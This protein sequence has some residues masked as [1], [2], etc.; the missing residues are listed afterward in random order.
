M[1]TLNL[2]V[3]VEAA[4]ERL[5]K[6]LATAVPNVSRSRLQKLVKEGYLLDADEEVVADN[7]KKIAAGDTFTLTIVPRASD[8]PP[9]PQD[10]PLDIL[11]EDDDIIVLNKAAGMVVHRGAGVEDG[12]LVNA[13]L[14]HTGGKLSSIGMEAGRPGIVHRL[15]KDT[16]G[17][18]LACKTDA[19]HIAM[20][21]QFETH[22]VRRDYIALAWSE[23]KPAAGVIKKNIAR[24]PRFHQ[25]MRVVTEGGKEA[26][27]RYKTL[28]VFKGERVPPISMLQCNLET[29][30]T[31]QIRV[32]MKYSG[33]PLLGDAMYGDTAKYMNMTG[34]RDAKHYLGSL[35]R[36][37]LHS[38]NIAFIH[39]T[40]GVALEFEA[41]MPK[42]MEETILFL[43]RS[44]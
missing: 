32:H 31:H 26:I 19:A 25:E 17:A 24:S 37:M 30:R 41:P 18:M 28:E 5:D 12:T 22:A 3:P 2:T 38:K 8:K 9:V 13:L 42:D 7:S 36:Q 21:R 39:P 4:G 43:R 1:E 27:T 34:N 14:Y 16:S 11:Y 6:W 44:L 40:R 10:L 35:R 29:G 23:A 33:F 20:Y 15:D